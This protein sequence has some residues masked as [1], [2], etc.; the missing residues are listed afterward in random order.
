MG[1]G[2]G[3]QNEFLLPI[4]ALIRNL[5]KQVIAQVYIET[6]FKI[7]AHSSEPFKESKGPYWGTIFWSIGTRAHLEDSVTGNSQETQ[8][9]SC[10]YR[11]AFKELKLRAII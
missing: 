3:I 8:M 1:G 9:S 11:V 7:G 5:Y 6:T 4:W 2:E 10:C